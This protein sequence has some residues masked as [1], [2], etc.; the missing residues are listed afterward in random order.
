MDADSISQ[1]LSPYRDGFP[2]HPELPPGRVLRAAD[3]ALARDVLPA[4]IAA[5]VADGEFT[6]EVAAA[7]SYPLPR[8]YLDA[9][10]DGAS[11]VG[12]DGDGNLTG[13]KAGLPFP[14]IKENEHDAGLK[15][16]WNLRYRSLGGDSE[17]LTVAWKTLSGGE[18]EDTQEMVT[19]RLRLSHRTTLVPAALAPNPLD[20]Y[21]VTVNELL[22]PPRLQGWLS[23]NYRYNDPLK[24]DDLWVYTPR[25]VKAL[26]TDYR[27]EDGYGY[28]GMVHS[29][30]WRFL[31]VRDIL[32]G[33]GLPTSV[34]E[35]GGHNGWYP[36]TP[37]QLRRAYVV[38]ALAKDPDHHYPRRTFYIDTELWMPVYTVGLDKSGRCFK[39]VFHLYGDP[40]HNL[41]GA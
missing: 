19:C 9:T 26:K 10:L 22:S 18:V 27:N 33:V 32:S 30:Q 24:A 20:L 37:F 39:V 2:Q 29:Q 36:A 16:A 34:P 38:E 21:E 35:Y 41:M 25:Q 3:A 1:A 7:K 40:A 15:I 11:A 6:V 14:C 8:G 31:G 17:A 5:R 4:E 23:A 12:L 13:Y 28:N